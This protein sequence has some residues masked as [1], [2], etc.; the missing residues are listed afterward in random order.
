MGNSI[1]WGAKI[2][3]GDGGSAWVGATARRGGGGGTGAANGCG[4]GGT[5]PSMTGESWGIMTNPSGAGCRSGMVWG[6]A[7]LGNRGAG[8][9]RGAVLTAGKLG[10]TLI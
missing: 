7:G 6:V 4:A 9:G 8:M 3:G 1:V 10:A 5:E 2:T